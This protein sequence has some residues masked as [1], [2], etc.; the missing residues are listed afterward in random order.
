MKRVCTRWRLWLVRWIFYLVFAKV[1]IMLLHVVYVARE[2]FTWADVDTLMMLHDDMTLRACAALRTSSPCVC[3]MKIYLGN[4]LPPCVHLRRRQA[5]TS[6]HHHPSSNTSVLLLIAL[7]AESFGLLYTCNN[8]LCIWSITTGTIHH[9]YHVL[10]CLH[11][12]I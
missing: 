1:K 8:T 5:T 2:R 3:K 11:S 10:L 6:T 7:L 12:F 4:N 9:H